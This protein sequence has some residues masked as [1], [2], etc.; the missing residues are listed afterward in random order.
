[1]PRMAQRSE[2][3]LSPAQVVMLV[4][5]YVLLVPLGYLYLVSG[6]VVPGPWIFLLWVAMLALIILAIRWWRRPIL[7]LILPFAGALFWVV[8]VQ[9]LGALFDWT[10]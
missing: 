4:V 9:G 10:A 8:F 2:R 6:L 3:T 7:V 5:G 1:M